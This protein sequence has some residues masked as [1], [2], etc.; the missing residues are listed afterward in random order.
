MLIP[1]QK[2]ATKGPPPIQVKYIETKKPMD[3]NLGKIVDASKPP[4]KKEKPTKKITM[5]AT[6]TDTTVETK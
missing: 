1:V 4:V 5:V 3:S 2:Q 6:E